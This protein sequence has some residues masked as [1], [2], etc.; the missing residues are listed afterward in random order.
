MEKIPEGIGRKLAEN[1]LEGNV[2][3]NEGLAVEECWWEKEGPETGWSRG[4]NSC[5]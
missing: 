3:E 2:T 4:G 1:I 5:E